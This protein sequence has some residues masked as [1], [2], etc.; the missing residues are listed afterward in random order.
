[1][2]W[3]AKWVTLTMFVLILA[4]FAV[5]AP[6]FDP[7]YHGGHYLLGNFRNTWLL[8]F[9]SAASVA[10]SYNTFAGDYTRYFP[11]TVSGRS[12][13][14]WNFIGQFIG[15]LVPLLAGAYAITIFKNVNT[16]FVLGLAQIVPTWYLV[17]LL[18]VGVIGTQPQGAVC[19]YSGGLS[20]LAVGWKVKRVQTTLILTVVGVATVYVGV[21]AF[22]AIDSISAYLLIVLIDVS[23]FTTIMLTGFALRRG[24]YDPAALQI[25]WTKGHG[26][27]RYWFWHGVKLLVIPFAIGAGIGKCFA[28]T[29]V[30]VGPFTNSV[31]GIDLSYWSAAVIAGVLYYLAVKIFPEPREVYLDDEPA[32]SRTPAEVAV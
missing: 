4:L 20:L 13:V 18:L 22:N 11:A 3:I 12:L 10:I 2:V 27:G 21:F 19:L 32:Q 7:S 29:T 16:P 1:M 8:A 23:P 6:K 30:F 15:L 26:K 25:F 31:G 14:G 9:G 28:D 24:R 17:L 5:L